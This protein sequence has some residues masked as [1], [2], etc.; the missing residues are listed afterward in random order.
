VKWVVFDLGGVLEVTPATGW[1]PRWERRL[2]LTEGEIDRRLADVW[3]AGATGEMSEAEVER[4]VA[5]DLGLDAGTLAACMDD[6]W[7]EYLGC[8]NEEL[9]AF[10]RTLPK[11]AILSNSF[12]GA[13]ERE[14]RAYALSTLTDHIIYSHE[15]GLLKP[16]PE[17]FKLTCDRLGAPPADCLLVDDHPPNVAAARAAGFQA[18]L[19]ED[20]P[21]TIAGIRTFLE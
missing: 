3:E 10:A 13:R 7:R 15:A 9:F 5:A 4:R 6:L 20:N 11:V 21:R 12:V 19:F 16:D 1:G 17:I 18:T 2:G 8:A 14:E